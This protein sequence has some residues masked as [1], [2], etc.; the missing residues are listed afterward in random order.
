MTRTPETSALNPMRK[1]DMP[2]MGSMHMPKQPVD[3]GG[4]NSKNSLQI[5]SEAI[6]HQAQGQD[7]QRL[8]GVL[9]TKLKDPN[10]RL[11]QIG[12]TVFFIQ[13]LAPDTIQF[14]T[15]SNEPL[16]AL[17]QRYVTA[18]KTLRQNGIRRVLMK[19]DRPGYMQVAQQV[20]QMVGA[21]V[22]G[23]RNMIEMVM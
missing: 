2:S 13:R 20:G 15:F 18:T 19:V 10:Y 4:G 11:L 17:M 1:K 8:L 22:R 21:Q 9:A 7:P 23:Q 6:Q 14:W 5:I 12:N 3:A 16:Q